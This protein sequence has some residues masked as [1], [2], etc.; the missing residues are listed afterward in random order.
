MTQVLS[1]VVR[2]GALERSQ[3]TRRDEG[4]YLVPEIDFSCLLGVQLSPKHGDGV[5]EL[6][7]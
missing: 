5:A 4:V 6:L 1:M 7:S 3:S 2:E